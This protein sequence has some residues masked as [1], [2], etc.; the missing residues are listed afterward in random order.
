VET[1]SSVDSLSLNPIMTGDKKTLRKELFLPFQD[2]QRAISNGRWKLHVYPKINHE[3]LFDLKTDPHETNNL[4]P[5]PHYAKQLK[6][7][8]KLMV[9]TR[10]D[11]G[12]TD[13]LRVDD[14]EPKEPIFDNDNRRLDGWQPQWI[15]DKYF[16]G[17]DD[18]NF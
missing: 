6:R 18:P 17:R 9:Q 14:P 2:N 3:L 5:D 11:Y 12:D 8:Q 16:G 1:P 13:P 10:E 7:M 15:R 4:A